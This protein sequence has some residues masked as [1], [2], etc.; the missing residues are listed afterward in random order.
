MCDSINRS[1]TA[2]ERAH[3]HNAVNHLATSAQPEAGNNQNNIL[4]SGGIVYREW[5]Q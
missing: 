3:V 5:S 4:L 2:T 1:W